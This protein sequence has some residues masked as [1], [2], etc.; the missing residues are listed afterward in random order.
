[1][2]FVIEM[3]DVSACGVGECAYNVDGDCHA[4]AITIGDGVHPG[5]DTY[6]TASH[7]TRGGSTAGVGACKVERCRHND[8]LECGAPSIHVDTEAGDAVC[9]TFE[10]S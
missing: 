10:T 2:K 4:K 9:T 6:L 5:C 8:D 7:H 1:M 3:P